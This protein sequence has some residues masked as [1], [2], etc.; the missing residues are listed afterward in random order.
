MS[1]LYY[2]FVTLLAV[3][4]TDITLAKMDQ[5]KQVVITKHI[6][7]HGRVC[8]LSSFSITWCFSRASS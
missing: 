7:A 1:L 4:Y 8:L 5:R 6:F 2:F 3:L